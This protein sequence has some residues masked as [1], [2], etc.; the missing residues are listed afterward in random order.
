MNEPLNG[1]LKHVRKLAAI[2]SA[3]QAPDHA[4][5]Q[6]FVADNDEAALTVLIERHGPM[7]LGVCRRA[8]R[9]EADAEDAFQATFLI[10]SRQAASIRKATS[11]GSWLHGVALRVAAKLKREIARRKL[12]ERTVVP[13]PARTPAD[14]VSWAEMQTA[15]DEEMQALPERY[16]AVLIRCYLDGKARDE[17]AREL[18]LSLGVL[19]GLLERGRKLLADRLTRRGLTLSAGL[20]GL[21]VCDGIAG[22]APS[23]TQVLATAQAATLFAAGQP[24]GKFVSAGVLT[25]SQQMLKGMI[26]TKLKLACALILGCALTVSAI[27]FAFAQTAA[28]PKREQP[29]ADEQA[30]EPRSIVVERTKDTDKEFIYRVSKDLRGVEPTPA[31]VHF[32]VTSKE[33]NKR[34]K[35]VDLFVAEREAKKKS[36]KE[37]DQAARADRYLALLEM[38]EKKAAPALPPKSDTAPP[39]HLDVLKTNVALAQLTVREKEL[40]LKAAQTAPEGTISKTELA[41]LEIEV[42][43]A[44]L[45][46]QR[47]E[48]ALAA[49][50]KKAPA[51]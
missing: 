4:L 45:L 49:A 48:H 50:A 22:A 28:Q 41:L 9:C 23:S 12:R 11:L 46:L 27:G 31:E 15:L 29:P 37:T 33:A 35:L 16:R 5:L 17:A 7:V 36:A 14:E 39:A 18:G 6:Q 38:V 19:R 44:R 20:L 32:F 25:L 1:V 10:F 3:R 40:R 51:K 34:E 24:V 42:A 21:A 26:M 30:V 47:A 43:R 13:P 8:L 2:Q